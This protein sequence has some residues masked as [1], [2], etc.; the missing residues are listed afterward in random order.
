MRG[1]ALPLALAVWAC[2]GCFTGDGTKHLLCNSD[3][4]CGPGQ[5]CIDDDDPATSTKYC[6]GPPPTATTSDGTTTQ[7]TSEA[8]T[9]TGTPTSTDATGTT[10]TMDAGTATE[11][12]VATGTETTQTSGST[13]GTTGHTSSTGSTGSSTG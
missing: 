12:T 1:L 3:A 10:T 6:D 4:S 8:T 5:S 9:Q 2:G 13:D 11:P 7:A